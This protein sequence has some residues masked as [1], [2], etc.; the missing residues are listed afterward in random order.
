MFGAAEAD[1]LRDAR[2]RGAILERDRQW[3]Q[4]EAVYRSALD[5][6]GSNGSRKDRFWLL[7]S[8]AEMSF[9]RQEYGRARGW[10]R[11]AEDVVG[12]LGPDSPEQARLLNAWGTLYLVEGNL[13]AAV[14]KLSRA[15]AISE[16]VASR[17]DLAAT[18][19]NLAG[20]E[21]HTGQV[22]DAAAHETRALA[23]WREELGDRH[24]YVMKAWISLSS[25]Q[26][27]CGNWH[28]AEKSVQNALAIAQTPEALANYAV[29]LDK[30]KR[31]SEAREIRRRLHAQKLSASP[32]IDV[33]EMPHEIARPSLWT[34]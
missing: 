13:T 18:L 17:A 34:Q 15:V 8:L 31:G 4:A 28:A 7:T 16:S 2:Q 5:R 29:I 9:E 21:M 19:H 11:K 14:Q 22:E 24:Y 23:L 10:L 20:L 32:L 27:F 1:S 3:A 25:L 30:L 6:L 26:G 12:D 33:K